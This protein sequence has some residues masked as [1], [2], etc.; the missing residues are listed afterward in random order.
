M[1]DHFQRLGEA[2][3]AHPMRP[4]CT[5]ITQGRQLQERQVVPANDAGSLGRGLFYFHT[6]CHLGLL[7]LAPPRTSLGNVVAADG[8]KG[9][10][11]MREKRGKIF[12]NHRAMDNWGQWCCFCVNGGSVYSRGRDEEEGVDSFEEWAERLVA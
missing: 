6:F 8:A 2:S 7:D 11:W 10:F 1:Q 3:V 9:G 5:S 4:S 12:Y